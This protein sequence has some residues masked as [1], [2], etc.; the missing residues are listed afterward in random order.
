MSRHILGDFTRDKCCSL[1]LTYSQ[2]IIFIVYIYIISIY[3]YLYIYIFISVYIIMPDASLYS[4]GQRQRRMPINA[5]Y[6]TYY[7][8]ILCVCV[9]VFVCMC[10]VYVCVCVCVYV[11]VDVYRFSYN[12]LIY[13]DFRQNAKR[14]TEYN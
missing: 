2:Y 6:N 3:I 1:I 14:I 4:V 13:S 7:D 8:C 12:V 10:V 11:F 5:S 9:C